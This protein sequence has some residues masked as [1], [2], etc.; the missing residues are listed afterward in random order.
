MKRIGLTGGIASGKST[1]AGWFIESDIPVVDA[2]FVYKELSKPGGVLYNDITRKFGDAIVSPEGTI[3]WKRLGALVFETPSLR[4]ELN[5]LT[6][7][8]VKSAMKD[9]L[10]ILEKQDFEFVVLSV[11]LLFETDFHE[12]CDKTI[13]V[14]TSLAV[15]IERLCR[16]DGITRHF[17]LQKIGAQLP[18][19]QKAKQATYVIDNSGDLTQ[20]RSQFDSVLESLRRTLCR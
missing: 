16:R 11:P 9:A 5:Q 15:Q 6:H 13:C 3:D 8:A 2:D 20:T 1:V 18:L 19:K 7:P 14:V 12:L 17:A 4:Q 10:A